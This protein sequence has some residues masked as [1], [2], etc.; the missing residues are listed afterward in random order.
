MT[1]DIYEIFK[2][3]R[4]ADTAKKL[5]ISIEELID[6]ATEAARDSY[7]FIY[8][9][10]N[11]SIELSGEYCSAATAIRERTIH[12]AKEVKAQIVDSRIEFLCLSNQDLQ[13]LIKRS[14]IRKKDFSITA[15]IDEEDG[16]TAISARN[17][18]KYFPATE[19]Y[20]YLNGTFKALSSD[21]SQE[22]FIAIDLP[23]L[24]IANHTLK[25]LEEVL[26]N[27][28]PNYG[29]FTKEVWASE[30]L[31][32]LNEASTF[33]FST[34]KNLATATPANIEKEIITWLKL[35]WTDS[36]GID[37]FEQAAK[38]ILPDQLYPKSAPKNIINEDT[39]RQYNDYAS[40]S[41]IIINESAK[42][43]WGEMQLSHRK[44]FEKRDVI[45][46]ELTE[47]YNITVKLA[48]A[49]ATII[50]PTKQD[51]DALKN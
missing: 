40:T 21:T 37:V 15:M 38:A 49:I 20:I 14:T 50:R 35:R 29:K 3:H 10:D 46:F 4:V 42:Y 2:V 34:E 32:D 45:K 36:L 31:V 27:R 39:R 22:K 30:K 43:Y 51:S 18:L 48:N 33:F 5:S 12:S 13:N 28:E 25:K 24:H 16:F 17:Y 11:T 26:T 44:S 41:L 1:N 6:I 23:D 8:T 47:K 9:P 7:F 19:G